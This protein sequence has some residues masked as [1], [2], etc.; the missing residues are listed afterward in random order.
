MGE[1][2]WADWAVRDEGVALL[3]V[4]G[5]SV[6]EVLRRW[7]QVQGPLRETNWGQVLR[8]AIHQADAPAARGRLVALRVLSS[9]EGEVVVAH[10]VSGVGVAHERLVA[11][12]SA[13]GGEAVSTWGGVGAGWVHAIDGDVVA[14]ATTSGQVVGPAAGAAVTVLRAAAVRR[15]ASVVAGLIVAADALGVRIGLPERTD[16]V[17][18]AALLPTDHTVW[19]E[20]A[21]VPGDV[22]VVPLDSGEATGPVAAGE[23]APIRVLG[24]YTGDA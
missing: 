4:R 24:L 19:P 1:G 17:F 3:I 13:G 2:S 18:A 15:D 6:E 16:T 22:P 7:G 20:R 10:D 8:D 12:V 21:P 14:S 5:T 11:A 23:V 9:R